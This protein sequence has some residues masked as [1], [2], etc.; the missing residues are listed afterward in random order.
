MRS[1]YPPAIA[2]T[3]KKGSVPEATAPG[4]GASGR[5]SDKCRDAKSGKE[6]YRERLGGRGSCYSSPVV[7]DNKIYI[8]TEGGVV[9]VF[10]PGDQFKVLAKNDL[11]ERIMATPALVENTSYLRTEQHLYAF[12]G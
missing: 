12:G 1:S 4:S 5:S 11:G 10:R 6:I 9:V 2:P 7:G 3:T 8:G